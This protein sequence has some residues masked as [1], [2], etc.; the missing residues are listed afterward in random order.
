LSTRW[1][2][3]QRDPQCICRPARGRGVKR[4]PAVPSL[5]SDHYAVT[6]KNFSESRRA[7]R[8]IDLAVAR[9]TDEKTT[10]DTHL[11]R[12]GRAVD[13][14]SFDFLISHGSSFHSGV[15]QT[16]G[17]EAGSIRV[18][19]GSFGIATLVSARTHVAP[20]ASAHFSPTL[21]RRPPVVRGCTHPLQCA[22]SCRSV[23]A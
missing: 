21:K 17:G 1:D 7:M 12:H 5:Q 6:Q 2:D 8:D 20:S 18:C 14:M 11:G 19:A 22:S 15:T 3:A 10:H 4:P 23:N 16:T 13:Q 9:P